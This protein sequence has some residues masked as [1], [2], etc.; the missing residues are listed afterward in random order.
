MIVKDVSSMS[1]NDIKIYM[2]SL[3]NEYE[4]KKVEISKIFE[5][6]NNISREYNKAKA[7]QGK[8]SGGF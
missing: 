8:R 7:E 6:M 3:E 5:D 4:A 2:L 1:N